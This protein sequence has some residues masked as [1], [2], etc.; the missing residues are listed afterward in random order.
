M[1]SSLCYDSFLWI[2]LEKG[3]RSNCH[4]LGFDF[5]LEGFLGSIDFFQK[6]CVETCVIKAQSITGK[7]S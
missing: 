5:I 7:M 2:P 6:P 4:F 3:K 1:N